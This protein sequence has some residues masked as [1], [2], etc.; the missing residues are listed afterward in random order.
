M[1]ATFREISKLW[2]QF[3]EGSSAGEKD[4]DKRSKKNAPK[5]KQDSQVTGQQSRKRRKTA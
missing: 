5:R 3:L 1:I 4:K 2:Y